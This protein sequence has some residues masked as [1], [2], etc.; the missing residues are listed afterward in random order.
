M[1][2]P[3]GLVLGA[4]RKNRR[5]EFPKIGYLGSKCANVE[6]QKMSRAPITKIY[7]VET[8]CQFP[9]TQQEVLEIL[10]VSFRIFSI[11]L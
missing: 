1:G 2:C 8:C 3:D 5:F 7:L 6:F 10:V 4:K 11:N 9:L